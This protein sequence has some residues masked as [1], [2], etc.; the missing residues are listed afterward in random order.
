VPDS[1]KTRVASIALLVFSMPAFARAQDANLQ[2]VYSQ[3]DASAAKFQDMQADI[4]VD[5]YT[6]VVQ[7]HEKQTGNTAFH[8][9]RGAMEMVMHLDQS[10]PSEKDLL[11]RNGELDVYSP[12]PQPQE[13]IFAAGANHALYDSLLATGVGANSQELSAAWDVTFQGMDTI[14]GVQTAK[15]DLVAK[16]ANIR[17]NFS[18]VTI[19][20][21]PARDISLKVVMT[22]PDG[23]SRTATYSNVRYNAHLPNSLFALKMPGGT[24]VQRH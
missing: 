17:S 20:V 5:N 19:W 2:K 3:I 6:A 14:D 16:Q 21:D 10:K 7:E 9:A 12:Q 1:M 13:M 15:L 4:D 18:H 11:Y 24:Q 22:Q 23:D 8:R